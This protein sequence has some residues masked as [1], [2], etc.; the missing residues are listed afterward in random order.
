[1]IALRAYNS[2]ACIRASIRSR[3]TWT[4]TRK[5][6]GKR[7]KQVI[8]AKTSGQKEGFRNQTNLLGVLKLPPKTLIHSFGG[9]LRAA[10]HGFNIDL[11]AAV[12]KLVYLAVIVVVIPEINRNGV[13]N[14]DNRR[15]KSYVM[16]CFIEEQFQ[17]TNSLVLD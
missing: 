17:M 14:S 1:M 7:E 13:S 9:L 4:C 16:L 15:Y 2:S 11:K 6:K 10:H 8:F 12:Q 5:T 3:L